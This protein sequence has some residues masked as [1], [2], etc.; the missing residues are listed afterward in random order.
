[1][2]LVCSAAVI[3]V[4]TAGVGHAASSRQDEGVRIAK[5]SIMRA[6]VSCYAIEGSYPY[7]FEYIKR[8]YR[9]LVNED[10]YAVDYRPIGSNIMPG[11]TVTRRDGA[12]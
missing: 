1:M 7:S 8:H 4:F 3:A 9:V 12:P 5:E 10:V 6:A 11:V 2:P